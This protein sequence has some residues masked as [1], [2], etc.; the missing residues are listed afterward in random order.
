M[1][2]HNAAYCAKTTFKAEDRV[3]A[4]IAKYATTRPQDLR[5]LDGG[6]SVFGIPL[7][8]REY[9]VGDNVPGVGQVADATETQVCIGG[10]WYHRQCFDKAA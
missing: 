3:R 9:T 10:V 8:T 4:L 6:H 2:L 7:P 1:W 5:A